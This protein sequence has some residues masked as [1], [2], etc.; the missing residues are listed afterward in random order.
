VLKALRKDPAGRYGSAAELAADLD[1]YLQGLPVLA[2][3]GE[4]P[5]RGWAFAAVDTLLR[6]P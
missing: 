1:R 5:R 4:K 2:A 6:R 3:Q